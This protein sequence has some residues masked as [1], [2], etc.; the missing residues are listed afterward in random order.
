LSFARNDSA[1]GWPKEFHDEVIAAYHEFLPDLPQVR[2][3]P[4]RRRRLLD[5]RI[6][7]RVKAGKKADQISYWRSLF[8]QVQASDFLRG[9]KDD[10]RCPGLEW[11]LDSENFLKVIEG[12]YDNQKRMNG[13]G[14][15]R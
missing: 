1:Q 14:H 11:L 9:Q 8:S 13:A 6:A 2:D 3:W 5:E 12:A 7:E 4:D 10:W 15:A